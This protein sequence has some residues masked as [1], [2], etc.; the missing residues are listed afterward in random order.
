MSVCP[1]DPE[2]GLKNVLIP[3]HAVGDVSRTN[4]IFF[5]FWY[6]EVFMSNPTRCTNLEKL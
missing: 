6:L 4:L 5:F 1:E 2:N 3:Y